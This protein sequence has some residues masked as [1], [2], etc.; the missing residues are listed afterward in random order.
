[1][2][3]RVTA[4][5]RQYDCEVA[6][7][8]IDNRL[9]FTHAPFIAKDE[10]KSM[11]GAR[12]NKEKK[13]WS[14]DA[15]HRNDFRLR[16]L[17]GENVYQTFDQ[18]VVPHD[19]ERPL[20]PHQCDLADSALTKHYQLWAAEMGTGKTLAAQE[21]IERSA[22]QW[23]WV[24]PKSSLPNIEREL[25]KWNFTGELELLSYESLVSRMQTFDGTLP[26][27]VVFDE[28]SRLKNATSLRAK[29]AQELADRIRQTYGLTGYVICMSGTPSPKTPLD[30]WS[31][32]EICW[33]GF[34]R[35]GS[36]AQ[37]EKRL[38][39]LR[40]AESEFGKYWERIGWRDDE[41]KCAACGELHGPFR[42][43]HVYGS[44]VNEIELLYERLKGL[45]VIKHK[46]DCL[47]LPDK[48]YRKIHCEPSPSTKRV[49]D[50]LCKL[51]DR[52]ATAAVWLR[53]LSDGFQY[54]EEQS[55]TMPCDHCNKTGV[56][57]E[58]DGD[59]PIKVE[60]PLCGGTK[61]KPRMVRTTKEVK[62]PK[63]EQLKLLLEE[64]EETGR[65]VIFAGFTGSVDRI[66][67]L[68]QE[69]NWSVV[70]CDGRGFVTFDG[71][72]KLL[73]A[74]PLD[75]WSD[76]NNPRVA[77]VAHPESGGMS[78]TLT[79]SR[80]A[81][82]W[83]NSFKPEFRIQAEDRIHRIS[84]DENKGCV[85]VDLIH[86]PTDERVLEIIRENRRLELMTLG[87]FVGRLAE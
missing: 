59:R 34:L 7:E 19:Y 13:Q 52:A 51:A 49:A 31:Q 3:I 39:F 40:E 14:I 5:S 69:R 26:Q 20:R 73:D 28:S 21:V 42:D 66:C 47:S 67:R 84:M 56:V 25:K 30:W 68:C 85:I 78:L 45:V 27:G 12:W 44:T 75:Y 54:R 17:S 46:K 43:D 87:E 33:P 64:C 38:A 9:V 70:R 76:K 10:I 62:C 36:A 24:G 6:V 18:P 16:F 86:L 60:C 65:I 77:F 63:D 71:D 37:L 81:V 72:G 8:Q 80:M 61:E 1:M 74:K 48:Q 2:Q 50:T 79:E 32:C 4:G 83:S 58:W 41:R 55:G 35:E 11:R 53:E 82:F 22:A 23:W 57:G 15:C 29:A